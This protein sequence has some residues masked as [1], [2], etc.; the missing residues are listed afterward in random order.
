VANF[1]SLGAEVTFSLPRPRIERV[2]HG[3]MISTTEGFLVCLGR[4]R[5]MRHC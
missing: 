3:E 1:F 2:A 4:V 5:P